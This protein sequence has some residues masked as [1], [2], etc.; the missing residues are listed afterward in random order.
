MGAAMGWSRSGVAGDLPTKADAESY[1]SVVPARWRPGKSGTRFFPKTPRV[2]RPGWL[3]RFG[4][5]QMPA[6][7]P[8]TVGAPSTGQS[9]DG[10]APLLSSRSSREMH[11]QRREGWTA[12]FHVGLTYATS[13]VGTAKVP[14]QSRRGETIRMTY[15]M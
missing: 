2:T 5:A 14:P 6:G 9:H 11:E 7:S 13:G 15:P 12:P 1:L 4:V 8:T 10:R 3:I